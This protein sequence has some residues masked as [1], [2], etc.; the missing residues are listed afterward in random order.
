MTLVDYLIIL[1]MAG[2]ISGIVAVYNKY[3]RTPPPQEI[4]DFSIPP[5]SDEQL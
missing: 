1:V 4:T 2:V 3:Y 5:E